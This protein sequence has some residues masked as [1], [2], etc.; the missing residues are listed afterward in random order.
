MNILYF[1]C[2]SGISGDMVLG[3]LIDAGLDASELEKELGKLSLEDWHLDISKVSKHGLAGTQVKVIVEDKITER[4][5]SEILNIVEKSSLPQQIIK[6]SIAILKRIGD[7]ESKIHGRPAA[8]LHL[9][10]LGGTDTI[11]DVVGAVIGLNLLKID[12]VYSSPVH[13]GKGFV[14]CAHGLLPVPAP[15]TMELLTQANTPIFGKD[16]EAELTTPTGAAILTYLTSSFGSLPPLDIDSIG[17]GA[18]EKDLP[19]PNLLRVLI[20]YQNTIITQENYIQE[21]CTSIE[22]NI[23]DMNPELYSYLMDRLFS[24]GALDVYMIPIYM[25]KNRPGI[26]L[27]TISE[28]DI[29]ENIV[30]LLLKETTTLGVR[31]HEMKRC[32][33]PREEIQVST[34]Y[35][36]VKV[37]IAKISGRITNISPEYESCRV[38]AENS[39]VSLKEVYQ[40]AS[41]ATL[42]QYPN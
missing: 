28:K 8:D 40:E 39:G 37:K 14:S 18:G 35:G 32:I 2:F 6:D 12:K 10:E 1:D 4:K 30:D 26:L 13:V 31:I 25:K 15:A 3:A 11:I 23:D 22:A 42:N 38:L 7:A 9:H 19:I 41:S 5:V 16:I 27:G 34:K 33:L 17:Y 24:I 20:G 36:D 29:V 21:S